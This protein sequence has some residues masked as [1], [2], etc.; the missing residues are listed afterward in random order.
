MNNPFDLQINKNGLR[1]CQKEAYEAILSHF[2]DEK[3]DKHILVQLPTGAG[4]S[5]LIVTIPFNLSEKRIL[6]LVPSVELSKQL[7]SDFD[8]YENPDNN[9]YKKFGI[10]SQENLDEI[11]LY[12]LRLE[13]AVNSS[14]VD[15]HQVIIANYHQL[16][17]IEKFFKGR[18]DSIDVIIIDEAHHQKA[19]TYQEIIKFFKN[20]KI[21]G[22]TG[23][24]FRS[25][26]QKVDG[27]N[28]YTY[29][30]HEAIKDKIIRNIKISNITPQE[31]ELSFTDDKG[32]I[33][34]FKDIIKLKEDAWFRRGIAMSEDCCNSIAKKAKDKLNDLQKNFPDTSHQIIASAI[35][36]RHAREFVKPAFVRLG[37]KVGMVSSHKEDKKNNDD[38]LN[39][40]KQGKLDV[41]IHVGMLGEGFDHKKLGVAAIFRPYKSLNPYIQFI[42]RVLR[43]NEDAKYCWVVSH[44]G[45][46]QSRRFD[47]FKMFDQDDQDFIRLLE[48]SEQESSLDEEKSFVDEDEREIS[49]TENNEDVKIKEIGSEMLDFSS[50]YVKDESLQI[51][52]IEKAVG[53]LSE[54]GKKKL[55]EK[56]GI[57]FDNID[58]DK[59]TKVKPIN[60]R[61]ASRNLLNEKEKSITTD[62][63]KSLGVKYKGRDFNKMFENFVWIKR[64]VSTEVNKKLNIKKN[65]RKEITN[66][67]FADIEKSKILNTIKDDC[68]SYF[69]DKLK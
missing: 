4:K 5:A 1:K 53:G 28:V 48:Q 65:Q 12:P 31:I 44:L 11:E 24:P 7:N 34:T 47:E 59:K 62:V 67:K 51:E 22:L 57:N 9:A 63:I 52:K 3:A 26:G 32:K 46:N 19:K 8:I 27:K 55:F 14:D 45:L 38:T 54:I 60:K 68:T 16:A 15:E 42:G 40:L 25:D 58:V 41:I 17:D 10:L 13:S 61:K 43:K 30:F 50:S 39:K 56:F 33:Y 35:S 69:K 29:H 21:I 20:A 49:E 2:S 6:V 18:E 36:I 23:T 66:E 64:K 37:L